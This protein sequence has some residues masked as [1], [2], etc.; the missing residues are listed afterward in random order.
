MT[1]DPKAPA[2]IRC[3]RCGCGDLRTTN[4]QRLPGGRVR[5]YK[6]CRH[7]GRRLVTFEGTAA[8]LRDPPG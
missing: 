2:G 8:A 4:T 7:C 6:A 5:R 1:T 3:P